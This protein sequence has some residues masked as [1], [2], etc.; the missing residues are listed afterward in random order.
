MEVEYTIFIFGY[1]CYLDCVIIII[2]F[3]FTND[4]QYNIK[5]HFDTNKLNPIIKQ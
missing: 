2:I 5:Y 3:F 1:G 4:N